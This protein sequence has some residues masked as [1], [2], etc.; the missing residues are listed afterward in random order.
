M[1]FEHNMTWIGSIFRHWILRELIG[2]IIL[3]GAIVYL[4]VLVSKRFA[5]NEVPFQSQ[6]MPEDPIRLYPS[7][8]EIKAAMLAAVEGQLDALRNLDFGEAWNYASRDLRINLPVADFERMV[9]TGFSVMTENHRVEFGGAYNNKRMGFVDVRLIGD[10]T[11]SAYFSYFLV[12]GEG[13]WYVSG[14]EAINPDS[15]EQRRPKESAA[16]NRTTR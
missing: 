5:V 7:E 10:G 15:F 14:V 11:S 16:G 4:P 9:S 6:I 13:R 1:V 2:V 12:V 8:G 3:L